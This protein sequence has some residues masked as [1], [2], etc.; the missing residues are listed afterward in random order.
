VSKHVFNFD[1][2]LSILSKLWPMFADE[3]AIVKKPL[4]DKS[5]ENNGC[6]GLASTKEK[7]SFVS[8]ESRIIRHSDIDDHFLPNVDTKLT[9]LVETLISVSLKM[10]ENWLESWLDEAFDAM[11]ELFILDHYSILL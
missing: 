5:R 11:L 7:C 4:I 9:S 6:N 10:I 2:F 1:V 3:V 8:I